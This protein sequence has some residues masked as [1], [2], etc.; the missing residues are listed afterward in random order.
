MANYPADEVHR[1][2]IVKFQGQL[3]KVMDF[4]TKVTVVAKN[5][6]P[7]ASPAEIKVPIDRL[8]K[9]TTDELASVKAA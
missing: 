5:I 8:K 4:P 9:P 3:F 7:G 2:L 1:G 6:R